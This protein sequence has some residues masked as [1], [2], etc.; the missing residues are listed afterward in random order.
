MI[1]VLSRVTG[2]IS[3]TSERSERV[4]DIVPVTS[5]KTH[6]TGHPCYD[7]FITHLKNWGTFNHG[8][9]RNY[10]DIDCELLCGVDFDRRS[11]HSILY[12]F[13]VQTVH[14]AAAHVFETISFG[15]FNECC[16]CIRHR[17][18]MFCHFDF[19]I[20]FCHSSDD[21]VFW[22]RFLSL[23]WR[24]RFDIVLCHCDSL[25]MVFTHAVTASHMCNKRLYTPVQQ[26][27]VYISRL[28]LRQTLFLPNY[29]GDLT[30]HTQCSYEPC[31]YSGVT[32]HGFGDLLPAWATVPLALSFLAHPAGGQMSFCH[33]DASVVRPSVVHPSSVRPSVVHN[34]RKSLF[35]PEF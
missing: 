22:Y 16:V 32:C 20:V 23:Q 4:S 30:V 18:D 25:Y 14:Q 19:D 26:V 8:K 29:L 31:H 11:V 10:F 2:T 21:I 9:P 34:S 5:D 7:L 12:P 1:W 15:W 35:L 6:I 24:Y 28:T 3:R 33:H 27:G 13:S 17:M